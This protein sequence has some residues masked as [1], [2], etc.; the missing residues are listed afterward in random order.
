LNHELHPNFVLTDFEKA[1]MNAVTNVFP[2]TQ[3]KGC[4]FH[5]AQS[6]WRKVQSSGLKRRY[7][8]DQNL[9]LMIRNLPALAFLNHAEIPQAFD[10]LRNIMPW[11]TEEIVQ[12]FEEN[13]VHGR[14]R[15]Q[16]RI[17]QNPRNPPL[18]PPEIWSVFENVELGFLR[19]Q[20]NVEAWHRRWNTLV[21]RPHV[22]LFTL[23]NEIKKE[24]NTNEIEIERIIRGEPNH[25]RRKKD[26][27]REKALPTII[28][29]RARRT[30][31]DFVRGIAHNLS[32]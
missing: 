28:A 16:V 23:I 20:N 14:V 12:W 6:T 5:L 10:D 18:F 22:G 3:C 17:G 2:G 19:T 15:N 8:R 32:L 24:Q 13:Y 31:L 11:G 21:G 7:G 29:S 30:T 26:E 27:S 4:L 25:K 9:S 1:P